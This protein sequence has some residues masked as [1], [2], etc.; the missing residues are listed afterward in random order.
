M[1]QRPNRSHGARWR[2]L[3]FTWRRQLPLVAKSLAVLAVVSYLYWNMSITTQLS[4]V[5]S[6]RSEN[7]QGVAQELRDSYDAILGEGNGDSWL[8]PEI[9]RKEVGRGYDRDMTV[10]VCLCGF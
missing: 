8:V 5:P 4:A 9:Y 3:R 6:L 2:A 1:Q 7:A 10:I